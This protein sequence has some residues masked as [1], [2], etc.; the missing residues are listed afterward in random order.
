[1]VKDLCFGFA[2]IKDLMEEF[3]FSSY[4]MEFAKIAYA[5]CLDQRNY[6]QLLDELT[7]L[8]EKREFRK[9]LE[10]NRVNK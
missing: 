3:I 8:A 10:E 1:L 9:Y 2:Q 4:K 7:F 5:N 6:Y